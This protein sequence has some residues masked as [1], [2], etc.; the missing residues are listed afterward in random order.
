M[1]RC[2][3][4]YSIHLGGK[5]DL[6]HDETANELAKVLGERNEGFIQM[7]YIPDA[8]KYEGDM[9]TH[10]EKHYE[11]LALTSGRPILYNAIAVNDMYPERYK[12][13]LAWLVARL[14]RRDARVVRVLR[15]P[16]RGR[17]QHPDV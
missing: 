14:L 8:S 13:Q 2:N 16:G 3:G 9:Q 11:E 4:K 1:F 15:R 12:R 7:S 10:S 17:G 6:M 5:T